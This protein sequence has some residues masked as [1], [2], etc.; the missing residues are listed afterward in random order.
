MRGQT[1]GERKNN[2]KSPPKRPE[3]LYNLFPLGSI[4]I[5]RS[6]D[7]ESAIWQG[8]AFLPCSLKYALD[9]LDI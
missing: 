9:H 2:P 3:S 1:G 5:R 4:P 6:D 8:F 7:K